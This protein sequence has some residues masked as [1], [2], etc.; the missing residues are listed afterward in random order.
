[1]STIGADIMATQSIPKP[2]P[3]HQSRE[4]TATSEKFTRKQLEWA[5]TE[6][7]DHAYNARLLAYEAIDI[8]NATAQVA[9]ICAMQSLIEQMGWIADHHG[10]SVLGEAA[11]WMLPPAYHEAAKHQAEK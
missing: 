5:F 2:T 4:T 6:I 11:N 7:A 8:D 10:G 1:M 9:L 3:E